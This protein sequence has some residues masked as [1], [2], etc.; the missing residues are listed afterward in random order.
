MYVSLPKN[1]SGVAFT[2]GGKRE[3]AEEIKA[4]PSP[5]P[6]CDI[7]S[8]R[9]NGEKKVPC[10]ECGT[11]EKNPIFCMMEALRTRKNSGFD[12]EDILLISLI[13]LLL[14]KEGNEDVVLILAMLLVI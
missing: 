10:E 12:A 6:L 5:L 4:P 2:N 1:Y 13:V 9:R 3:T 7:K 14:S 8:E 11:K